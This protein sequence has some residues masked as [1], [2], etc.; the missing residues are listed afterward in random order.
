MR[1]SL[2]G[3]D[4]KDIVTFLPE[5]SMGPD[6]AC[7]SFDLPFMILEKLQHKSHAQ[8]EVIQFQQYTELFSTPH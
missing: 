3:S 2:Q 4:K 5:I 8:S 6:V 7:Y 1:I